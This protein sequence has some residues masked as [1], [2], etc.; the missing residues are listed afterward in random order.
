MLME[1]VY[2]QWR[3]VL[4]LVAAWILTL[5]KDLTSMENLADNGDSLAMDTPRQ[6][7][8]LIDRDSSPM[9]APHHRRFLASMH[10]YSIYEWGMH[11]SPSATAVDKILS[12]TGPRQSGGPCWQR[13]VVLPSLAYTIIYQSGDCGLRIQLCCRAVNHC[14]FPL[15]TLA[16]V[17]DPG[18]GVMLWCF[19]YPLA[20]TWPVRI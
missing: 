14:R 9:E 4:M 3:C 10:P 20:R 16:I 7:R 8:P 11:R 1:S 5:V 13:K 12:L 2:Q 6:C 18:D 15:R 19:E 17:S